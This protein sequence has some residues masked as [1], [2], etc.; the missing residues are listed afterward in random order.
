M[1]STIAELFGE[2]RNIVHVPRYVL[3]TK[4]MSLSSFCVL[5]RAGQA[6]AQGIYSSRR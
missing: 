1:A 2:H 3:L 6:T 5:I 4:I